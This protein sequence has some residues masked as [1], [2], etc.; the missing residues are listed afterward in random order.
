MTITVSHPFVSLKS[1][2]ADVTQVSKNEWN[3]AHTF[4]CAT[5]VLL[6]RSTAGSGAVEEIL[7][8]GTDLIL[9]SGVLGL[10]QQDYIRVL[11]ADGTGSD[12]NTAQAVFPTSGSYSAN[13][14]NAYVFD[15]VLHITRAAG[16]NSHT[17]SLLF[18]GTATYTSLRWM[19]DVANPTGTVI[20]A[21]SRMIG[22]SAAAVVVT[23]ANTS[24]TENLF[25]TWNGYI[26][27]NGAGTIIP[28]FQYSAAPGG[29]PTIKANSYFRLHGLGSGSAV[30][31]I[32]GAWA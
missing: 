20:A 32:F 1:Q 17:T 25:I 8:F 9:S 28:Q 11:D 27:T 12:V 10:A 26:R 15:A 29:A 16:I 2:G 7:P 24:A 4:T 19:A 23:A 6:G 18:G 30:T 21:P 14:T 22:A 31:N 3:N 13:A 5:N